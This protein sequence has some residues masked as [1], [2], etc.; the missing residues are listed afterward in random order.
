[1][2]YPPPRLLDMRTPSLLAGVVLG[3]KT[4]RRAAVI[5]SGGG[6]TSPFTTPDAGCAV[7]M[8][9][10]NTDTA[11]RAALLDAGIL[12]FTAPVTVGGGEAIADPGWSGFAEPP[13]VLPSDMTIDSVGDVEASAASLARFLDHL[14]EQYGVSDVDIV[15]HSL[16]GVIARSAHMQMRSSGAPARIIS[17]TSIGTPWLGSFVR[18]HD[19]ESMPMPEPAASFAH[20]L[21]GHMRQG[22]RLV[23]EAAAPPLWSSGKEHGLDGLA[24][25]RIAGTYF[26][27]EG[28]PYPHDGMASRASVFALDA[29]PIVFPPASCL[30]VPDVHSISF[31]RVM[32]LD[33]ERSIT[34]D[35]RVMDLVVA[36]I[37]RV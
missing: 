23:A 30:E 29:D 19:L 9:A 21:M 22:G 12:T 36:A 32:D 33:W 27:G 20:S 3:P 28:D 1:M 10:G 26:T 14:H 18:H 37:G 35:P 5:V 4:H 15:A 25:T 6:S 11:L 16:G 8:A 13:A 31:A 17:L 34:W 2:L 7:G 24:L